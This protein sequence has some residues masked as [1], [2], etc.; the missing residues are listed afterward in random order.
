MHFHEFS[1]LGITRANLDHGNYRSG[2]V[3][4]PNRP[5]AGPDP[6]TAGGPH[7]RVCFGNL[8]PAPSLVP[9]LHYQI[10]INLVHHQRPPNWF[11]LS[12]GLVH[13]QPHC[14]ALANALLT[15]QPRER[16][17]QE[18]REAASSIQE[19]LVVGVEPDVPVLEGGHDA[20]H[21]P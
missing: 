13:P 1:W 17:Y 16:R 6:L 12:S 8:P 5:H 19:R 15:G 21:R 7:W 14:L 11:P 10:G 20:G 3:C 9:E 18:S 2:G 4:P